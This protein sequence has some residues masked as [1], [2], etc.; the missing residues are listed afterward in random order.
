MTKYKAIK[1]DGLKHDYHR[2]LMEQELG[3]KLRS[4]EV[5][6]HINE[7]KLDNDIN[8]LEVLSKSE[9]ARHKNFD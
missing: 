5:V 9:H 7:N 1:V 6:H 3:R 4:D 2:W 8:N